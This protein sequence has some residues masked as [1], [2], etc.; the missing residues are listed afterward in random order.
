MYLFPNVAD[1]FGK[2]KLD[3]RVHV[4]YAFVDGELSV[5]YVVVYA[6][7]FFADYFQLVGGNEADGFEHGGVGE[8]PDNIVRS[9]VKVHLAVEAYGVG[10]YIMIN[11]DRFF[12]KFRCHNI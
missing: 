2:E 6:D 8:R 12:P 1:T 3:L 5:L 11:L 9:K 4:F 10:F 7:E